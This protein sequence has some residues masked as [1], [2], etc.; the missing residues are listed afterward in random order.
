MQLNLKTILI[1]GKDPDLKKWTIGFG[2]WPKPVDDVY[3]AVKWIADIYCT[4]LPTFNDYSILIQAPPDDTTVY[5]NVNATFI[6]NT[7]T[8]YVINELWEVTP[9]ETSVQE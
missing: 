6:D 7:D 8:A 3:A 9:D 1:D 5:I 4:E 2:E